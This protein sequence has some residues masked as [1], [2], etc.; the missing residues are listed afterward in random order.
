MLYEVITVQVDAD[1]QGA[2]EDETN[3]A[4]ISHRIGRIPEDAEVR[5]ALMRHI[6]HEGC[7]LFAVPGE[8]VA[9]QRHVVREPFDLVV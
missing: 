6:A 1:G 8:G 2:V 7:R 4:A 3:C 9:A 5:R